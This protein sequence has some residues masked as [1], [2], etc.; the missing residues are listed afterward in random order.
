MRFTTKLFWVV[1]IASSIKL[2]GAWVLTE[3]DLI[4][5]FAL[6]AILVLAKEKDK[7]GYK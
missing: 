7:D 4:V 6:V 1:F 5:L 2:N 3:R